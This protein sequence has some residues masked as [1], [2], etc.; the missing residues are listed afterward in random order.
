MPSLF[1]PKGQSQSTTSKTITTPNFGAYGN[2]LSTVWNKIGDMAAGKVADYTG[3]ITAGWTA[4]QQAGMDSYKTL[5]NNPYLS[6][7]LAGGSLDYSKDPAFLAAQSRLKENLGDAID[8]TK[9]QY[10]GRGYLSSSGYNKSQGGNVDNYGRSQAELEGQFST[11]AKQEMMSALSSYGNILNGFNSTAN[12]E[13]NALTEENQAKYKEFL[14]KQGVEESA[15]PYYMQFL[16]M[17]KGQES[18]TTQDST[19][20]MRRTLLGL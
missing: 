2:Q 15:I 17:V 4:N 5:M 12:A 13:Q 16:S 11:A 7:V 19:T 18:N 10:G 9:T 8:S 14:R 6:K 1:Q 3:K 20:D